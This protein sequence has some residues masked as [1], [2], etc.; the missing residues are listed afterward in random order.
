MRITCTTNTS[1]VQGAKYYNDCVRF[2]EIKNT[3]S[4]NYLKLNASQRSDVHDWLESG[5]DLIESI[6]FAVKNLRSWKNVDVD[7]IFESGISVF[8]A[9]RGV[10][11]IE[12][13]DQAQSLAIRLNKQMFEVVGDVLATTGQDG[14]PLIANV[15]E[16]NDLTFNKSAMEQYI[17]NQLSHHYEVV[18]GEYD[19]SG[20][21]DQIF[22]F[23]NSDY[24]C[25]EFVYKGVTFICPKSS[26]WD[27]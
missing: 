8:K 13:F 7:S 6:Q 10:P 17:I 4:I 12:N 25:H 24:G 27:M 1:I 14:E 16:V 3:V 11:I 21:G 20:E 9:K 18:T 15:R 23:W 19:T 2:G 26:E 22:S 5:D